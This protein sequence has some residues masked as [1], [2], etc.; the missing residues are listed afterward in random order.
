MEEFE[1]SERD[2]KGVL[3]PALR[4]NPRAPSAEVPASSCATLRGRARNAASRR[5]S[6]ATAAAS[7]FVHATNTDSS[8]PSSRAVLGSRL[9]NH[10]HG[11][12]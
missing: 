12:R 6:S 8:T 10:G 9:L 5:S 1:K 11:V 3:E 7:R 4:C 2:R